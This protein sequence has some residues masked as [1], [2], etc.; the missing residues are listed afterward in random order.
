[1]SPFLTPWWVAGREVGVL[2]S[3]CWFK[4]RA[5]IKDSLFVKSLA[6]ENSCIQKIYFSV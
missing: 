5:D 6:F 1:M 3:L 4:M 2:E